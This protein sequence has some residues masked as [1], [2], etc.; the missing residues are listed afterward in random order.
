MSNYLDIED[1]D[2]IMAERLFTE[3]WDSS[4]DTNKTKALT[5]ATKIIDTLNYN[6]EKANSEQVNEFPRG[7]DTEIPQ[8][9]L[10]A[11]AEIAL[12]LL[13]EVDPQFEFEN[14]AVASHAFA[15]VTT[16]Y[17]RQFAQEHLVAGVPSKNAWNLL[18]PYLRDVRTVG[19]LRAT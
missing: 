10:E 17:A 1:A 8:S 2:A 11:C 6:G 19:L 5:M 13:E 9:I 16:T 3:T 4:S 15:N 7:D 12:A 14:L 18:Q